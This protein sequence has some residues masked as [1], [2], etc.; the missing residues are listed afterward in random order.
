MRSLT[1]L[2]QNREQTLELLLAVDPTTGSTTELV[3]EKD[4][5]WV[6]L[7]AGLPRWLPSGKEF[8]WSSERSGNW[9]LELR[10]SDGELLG[11][12]VEEKLNYRH[13]LGIDETADSVYVAAGTMQRK[14]TSTE[15]RLRQG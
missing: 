11:P 10:A 3:R 6:N 12:L 4:E 13:T 8:L 14:R 15:F 2:V 7:D 5:A 9:K 1:I